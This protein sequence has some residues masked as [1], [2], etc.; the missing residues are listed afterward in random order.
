M[1]VSIDTFRGVMSRWTTGITVVTSQRGDQRSGMVASSFTSVSA[2]PVSVLFCADH[3]TRTYP[4]VRESGIFAV[5]ILSSTQDETFWIF[6]GMKGDPAADRFATLETFSAVTG[7]PI[8]RHSIA[9]LDCRVIAE[10]KGGNTHS[11]FVGEVLDADFGAD[12]ELAPLVYFNRK[13]RHLA[14]PDE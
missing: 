13:V 14:D 6:A 9:W 2:D 7:A 11:I 12:E 3:R 4:V 1:P 8:L 10:H 5:N